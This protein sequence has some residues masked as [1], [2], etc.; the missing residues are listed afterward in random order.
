MADASTPAPA[1]FTPDDAVDFVIDLL[2]TDPEHGLSLWQGHKAHRVRGE[3]DAD[4][5][6]EADLWLVDEL[7]RLGYSPTA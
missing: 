5:Q 1:R 6:P 4:D 3:G 7:A 2:D